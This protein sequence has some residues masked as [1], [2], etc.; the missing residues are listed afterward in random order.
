M[1]GAVANQQ[2]S[3]GGWGDRNVNATYIQLMVIYHLPK[4]WYLVSVPVITANWEADSGNR[5]TVPVGGGAGKVVK[6]GESAAE[7]ATTGVLQR[8]TAGRWLRLAVALPD[9]IPLSKMNPAAIP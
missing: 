6:L 4:G 1:I 8:G 5:W 3:V 9:T 2:W 7:L